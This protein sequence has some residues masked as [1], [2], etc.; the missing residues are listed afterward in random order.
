MHIAAVASAFPGNYH[1]Q[2]QV[3]DA[4]QSAWKLPEEEARR[5]RGLFRNCGVEG[6]HCALPLERYF[7]FERFGEFN[8]AWIECALELGE[9][10]IRDALAR[11]RVEPREIELLIFTTVTG[12]A[13]PSLDARLMNRIDFR[14]D[15]RRMPLFG[16]GCVAGAAGLARASD[17]LAARPGG[18]ALLLSVELCSLN[19]QREDRR[20]AHLISTGL[21]GDGAAAAVIL[22]AERAVGP[23][24]LASRSVFYPDTE[25]LMGWEIGEHGFSLV[26]SP[27]VPAVARERLGSDVDDFLR[28]Q[29]LS[30]EDIAFWVCHPG[31]PKVLEAAGESLGIGREEL[32]VSWDSLRRVG[33]LSSASVLHVLERTLAERPPAPGSK[34]ILLAMGPGF[35]SELLLLQA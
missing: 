28:A 6:R 32:R 33:N 9:R 23:R 30:R 34:G 17:F 19:F 21:F 3:A 27:D 16:L 26:L 2:A 1:S 10:A 35:C 20:P 25:E 8:D 22:G 11:A 14:P 7:E 24:I 13:A 29:G 18:A 15:T 31:G 4:L 5:L 12:L